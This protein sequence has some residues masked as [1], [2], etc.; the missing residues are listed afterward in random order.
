M[1]FR[2]LLKAGPEEVVEGDPVAAAAVPVAAVP[3]VADIA[4]AAVGAKAEGARTGPGR[5]LVR[6]GG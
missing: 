4:A 2:I 6:S 3:A 5:L 1:N